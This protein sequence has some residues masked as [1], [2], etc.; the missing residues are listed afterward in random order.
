MKI[1]IFNTFIVDFQMITNKNIDT[2]LKADT[3]NS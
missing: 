2:N 1:L 3:K